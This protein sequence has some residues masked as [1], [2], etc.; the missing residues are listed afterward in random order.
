MLNRGGFFFGEW[1][2]HQLGHERTT[3]LRTSLMKQYYISYNGF[4]TTLIRHPSQKFEGGVKF[5][6]NMLR[7]KIR[8]IAPMCVWRILSRVRES[9]VL[10]DNLK[11]VYVWIWV[12][13]QIISSTLIG[14]D[15]S[16]RVINALLNYKRVHAFALQIYIWQLLLKFVFYYNYF[17]PHLYF[18]R[19]F[20]ITTIEYSVF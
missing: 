10:T 5:V 18:E 4:G 2:A 12:A 16:S 17:R 19:W 20:V 1:N 7:C 15:N 14:L 3:L 8:C 13:N 11:V 9:K 6:L